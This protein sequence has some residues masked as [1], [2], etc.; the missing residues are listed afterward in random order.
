MNRAPVWLHVLLVTLGCNSGTVDDK[1]LDATIG[2]TTDGGED[3]TTNGDGGGD[4]GAGDGGGGGGD[5]AADGSSG[6]DS[7]DPDALLGSWRRDEAFEVE[8]FVADVVWTGEAD[9]VCSV[10]LISDDLREIFVCEY[11]ADGDAFT[12]TDDECDGVTGRYTFAISGDAL[13]F[14]LVDDLCEDR[15]VAIATTWT[16]E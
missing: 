16:R 7:S 13:S 1:D 4:D 9:G 15:S 10:E 11:T 8:E 14:T 6:G 5:G 2:T 12:I 3:G